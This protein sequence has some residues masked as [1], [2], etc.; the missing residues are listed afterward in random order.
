LVARLAAGHPAVQPWPRSGFRTAEGSWTLFEDRETGDAAWWLEAASWASGAA[1]CLVDGV[2]VGAARVFPASWENLLRLKD[3]VLAH[4]PGSTIFPAATETLGRRTSGVGARFTT[5]HWPA[6]EWTM[7]A[8]GIGVTANQNSIPRELVYDVDAML[9]GRLDRVPFPFIGTEVPEGHQG[10]SVEG[11]SRGSVLSKLRHGFH[12]LGIAWSFNA[13][14][15]PIGG[16]FDVRED[17]LVEGCLLASY[18]TFDL[19]PRAGAEPARGALRDRSRDRGPG[20]RADRVSGTGDCRAG[21]HRA[22]RRS[23]DTAAEDEAPGREVCG[24][25]GAALPGAGG[26]GLPARALDRRAAGLAHTRETTA[27]S[28]R[29]LRGPAGCCGFTSSRRPSASRRTCPI[30][31]TRRSGP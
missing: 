6:V 19:S 26:A 28:A 20:A 12:H 4:A 1:D 5:L 14:H 30:R 2:P 16:K 21:L 23:V 10:Q 24:G 31:T 27:V 18:I 3:L 25:P 9:G 17:A 8:L 13:D 15:Q 11:M 29:A 22:R 7:A